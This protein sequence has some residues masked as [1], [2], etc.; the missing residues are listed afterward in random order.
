MFATCDETPLVTVKSIVA[1]SDSKTITSVTRV[2]PLPRSANETFWCVIT[3]GTSVRE[4]V[5]MIRAAGAT[6]AGVVIALDRMERGTG[7]Q[8]AVEEVR[9][10][11]GIPVIAVDFGYTDRHVREFEPS[12][13]ISSY[14]EL[15]LTL[16]ER[17]IRA[18]AAA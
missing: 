10:M 4:S 12:A 2:T 7:T 3:A 16:A 11:F 8:S 17:L 5:A 15:T 1:K 14:D 9:D 6:P 18:A 13:I